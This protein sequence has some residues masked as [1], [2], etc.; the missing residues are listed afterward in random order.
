MAKPVNTSMET[1]I[2]KEA[3]KLDMDN[4]SFDTVTGEQVDLKL[5]VRHE[6][7]DPQTF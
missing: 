7:R 3:C 5:R 6:I 4:L 1:E 2:R